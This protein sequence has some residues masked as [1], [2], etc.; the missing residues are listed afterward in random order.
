VLT[1]PAISTVTGSV[2]EDTATSSTGRHRSAY[3]PV[4]RFIPRREKSG[5]FWSAGGVIAATTCFFLAH[6]YVD[7][8]QASL[9]Y[10]PVVIACATRFGFGP[11]VLAALLSFLCWNYFFLHPTYTLKVNHPRDWLSLIVFLL[12]AV[13][14]GQ[15]AARARQEAAQ[16]QAREA[17]IAMLFEASE[18]L[19]H[20]VSAARLLD[21]LAQQLQTLCR[22]SRCLVFRYSP[23]APIL[24][25]VGEDT[26]ASILPGD[27]REQ[28]Q[29]VAERAFKEDRAI[30]LVGSDMEGSSLTSVGVFVPL[31]AAESFVGVLHVGPRKDGQPFSSVEERLILTLANHAATVLARETLAEQAAQAAALRDADA[32]KDALLSLV[33]HELRTPLATIKA[34][35]SGLLQRDAHWDEASREEALSAI[36]READRLTGL[37]NHLLDLSRLEAGAWKPTKDWCS[38][39]EIVATVLDRL[40]E[41]VAGRVVV[42]LPV[43]LPLLRA[44]YIQIALVLQNLLE[45]AA[46][47]APGHDPIEVDAWCAEEAENGDHVFV[48]VRDFGEGITPGEEEKLF[49][50]FYRGARHRDG[51]VHGTGL[52]L[53]LCEAVVRAHG[54]RIWAS[55]AP[56]AQRSGAVFSF[57]LPV[58]TEAQA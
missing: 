42:S 15:L 45:N 13:T 6:D 35:A 4:S 50:R 34:S 55:N 2:V 48:T 54:G 3:G 32:L 25:I 1:R 17:E 10:L 53:A 30:G 46:K 51:A 11:A 41:S 38:L 5:Y 31:H 18:A 49:T 23:V 28:V 52:G 12:A 36:D 47:Y 40:P 9:L 43:E 16:A 56:V 14:T 24:Q 19:N 39:P 44:D 22:A 8:G 57:C 26:T 21:V 37:V 29:Q 20:E 27:L 33:S 7:K 58:D